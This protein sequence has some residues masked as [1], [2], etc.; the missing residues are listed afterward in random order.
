MRILITGGN[1]FIGHHLAEALS[2]RGHEVVVGIHGNS[3]GTQG[4]KG[5]SN[6]SVDFTTD[7]HTHV[8]RQRLNGFDGVINSVGIVREH[9]KQTFE[10]L[11][12]KAPIALF[13]ACQQSGVKRVI[14]ISA[15]GAAPNACS[16][17]HR[18]KWQ[19]DDYLNRLDLDSV[20]IRPSIVYGPGA[21][22]MMFFKTLSALPLVPLIGDG[23]QSIQPIHI[24]DFCQVIVHA[25]ESAKRVRKQF[26]IVGPEP[27]QYRTLMRQLR[28]WHGLGEPKF[29]NLPDRLAYLMARCLSWNREL[30]VSPE[31]VGMLIS[32]N[33]GDVRETAGILGAMPSRLESWL[34]KTPSGTS[35]RWYARLYFVRILL[36][37]AIGFV[38]IHTGFISIFAVP[39]T[40]SFGLL[41]QVGIPSQAAPLFLYGASLLDIALGLA[42]LFAYRTQWI[43]GL[44]MM[45]ILGYSIIITLFLPEYWLQPFGPISKNLPLLVSTYI[46]MILEKKP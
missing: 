4:A 43:G 5:S 6:M 38:W 39:E 11:H 32:G 44:Q 28:L 42:T 24:D 22:S 18:S 10:T 16:R 35:D 25:I 33:T 23:T 12:T 1:G 2:A 41:Q 21:K 8:W 34:R 26:D 37:I 40:Y 46:M 13:R 7:T 36:R 29:I 17:Y 14:Q 20:V 31:T 9:G 15:L 30:P 45:M 3:P 27:L 19:A